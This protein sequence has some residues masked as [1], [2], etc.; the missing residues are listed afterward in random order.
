MPASA[1]ALIT[2]AAARSF[3]IQ[4]LTLNEEEEITRRRSS[5][6]A[7]SRGRTED[8]AHITAKAQDE[9]D[10]EAFLRVRRAPEG[11]AELLLCNMLPPS[12]QLLEMHFYTGERTIRD[13]LVRNWQLLNV[14]LGLKL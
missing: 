1:R 11:R 3:Q 4:A 7:G 9:C 14:D 2:D 6:Q 12:G 5:R 10:P 8:S 13:H